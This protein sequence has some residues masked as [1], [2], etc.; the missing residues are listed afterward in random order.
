M[1]KPTDNNLII[2]T[3]SL[4]EESPGGI[5]I[6]E[7]FRADQSGLLYEVVAVGPGKRTKRGV[8]AP[9]ECK[10][11]DLIHLEQRWVAQLIPMDALDDDE[12]VLYTVPEDLVSHIIILPEGD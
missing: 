1:L 9:C 4:P 11:G 6:P 10:V 5:L 7:A 2:R 3:Y 8:R 12:E